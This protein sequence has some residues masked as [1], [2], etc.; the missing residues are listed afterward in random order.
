MRILESGEQFQVNIFGS[1]HVDFLH[2]ITSNDVTGL[3]TGKENF[4]C[5][6]DN[7]GKILVPFRLRKEFD[8]C[9]VTGPKELESRLVETIEKYI[10]SEDVQVKIVDSIQG[11]DREDESRILS[12]GLIWGKDLDTDTIPWEANLHE[13]VSTDKGCYT[14]QE[15]IAR[16]ETYGEV[17][18]RLR[19]IFS[20][21][22]AEES[23][24]LYLDKKEVGHVS[25]AAASHDDEGTYHALALL[26]RIVDGKDEVL[27]EH[28]HVWKLVS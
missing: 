18:R 2:R 3:E 19:V 4:H 25:T 11:A 23:S 20:D 9:L 27:G 6:L 16:I 14:G 10:F 15:V 21:V 28:G 1:D 13:Y 12:G 22:Q 5:L 24:K 7:K 17:P 26:K 8:H